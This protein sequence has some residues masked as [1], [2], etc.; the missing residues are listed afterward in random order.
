MD[1]LLANW[2]TDGKHEPNN[3][4]STVVTENTNHEQQ[5]YKIRRQKL[6]IDVT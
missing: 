6:F 3:T 1:Y 4:V 2:A 5:V